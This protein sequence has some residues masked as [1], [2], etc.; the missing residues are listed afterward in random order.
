MIILY[1]LLAVLG[2]VVMYASDR[3]KIIFFNVCIRLA[4]NFLLAFGVLFFL[5]ALL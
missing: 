2:S 3:E 4:G 5:G 1:I